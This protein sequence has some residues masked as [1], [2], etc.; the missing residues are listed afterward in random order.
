MNGNLKADFDKH[1]YA[2]QVLP[3]STTELF[4][5]ENGINI[6]NPYYNRRGI[7]FPTNIYSKRT[8]H[9]L[10]YIFN[11]KRWAA[12]EFDYFNGKGFIIDC[13]TAIKIC[14]FNEVCFDMAVTLRDLPENV[15]NICVIKPKI[16]K[17]VKNTIN[18]FI[19][20]VFHDKKI[21]VKK[22]IDDNGFIIKD[23]L[24]E[25][26]ELLRDFFNWKDVQKTYSPEL[27]DKVIGRKTEN[28]FAF[29]ALEILEN[30]FKELKKEKEQKLHDN[31]IKYSKFRDLLARRWS[32][33]ND[34]IKDEYNLKINEIEKQIKELCSEF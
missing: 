3:L 17:M 16:Y 22:E 21:T 34:K 24:I 14:K 27:F 10:N 18:E 15:N 9:L 13:G 5:Y 1:A 20:C 23:V 7:L 4:N 33:T 30:Q 31:G 8:A 2:W 12:D 25:E 28:Q 19:K 11:F 29:S 26:L 32:S 6:R